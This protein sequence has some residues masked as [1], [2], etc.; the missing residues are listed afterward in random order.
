MRITRRAALAY[1]ALAFGSPFAMAKPKS[2]ADLFQ[3]MRTVETGGEP[4]EGRDAIGDQGRSL[5][6]LQIGRAYHA[7]SRVPGRWDDVRDLDYAKRVCLAYW[8]RY[9]P[10]A[11]D[12]LDF[13]P[14]ARTHNGGPKGPTRAATL[15]Y[16]RKIQAVL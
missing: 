1:C 13:E 10:A 15:P 11:L 5:G 16:W 9:C 3:A 14:L 12:R 6:P 7:D 2:I 8:R 4:N